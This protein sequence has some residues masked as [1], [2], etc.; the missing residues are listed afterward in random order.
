MGLE[1]ALRTTAHHFARPDAHQSLEFTA[2]IYPLAIE[3]LD[4]L[5]TWTDTLSWIVAA[6]VG[7][8]HLGY[9]LNHAFAVGRDWP[10]SF[11]E[12]FLHAIR[13]WA[14]ELLVACGVQTC[15][16]GSDLS[17]RAQ[18]IVQFRPIEGELDAAKIKT[19]AESIYRAL[20]TAAKV[21]R[22]A[23]QRL[24]THLDL[25]K[26]EKGEEEPCCPESF[27]LNRLR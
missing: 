26:E 2:L 9:T 3:E 18:L 22:L 12:R 16:R 20:D 19:V 7:S 4:L 1:A 23:L 5:W 25:P 8:I 6:R 21:K 15:S 11:D 10:E 24:C 27:L 13:G 17:D 14:Q